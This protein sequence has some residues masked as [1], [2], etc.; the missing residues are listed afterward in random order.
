MKILLIIEY[1]LVIKVVTDNAEK[2]FNQYKNN[3]TSPH[4]VISAATRQV[5]DNDGAELILVDVD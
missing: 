3:M 1:G 2:I 4:E 5:V